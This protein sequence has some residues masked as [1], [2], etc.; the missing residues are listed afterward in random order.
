MASN[1]IILIL[2]RETEVKRNMPEKHRIRQKR[3]SSKAVSLRV[4]TCRIQATS[5]QTLQL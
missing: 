1:R 2:V 5:V 4:A 3:S